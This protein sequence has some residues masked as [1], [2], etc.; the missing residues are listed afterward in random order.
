MHTLEDRMKAVG[1]YFKYGRK[2]ATARRELGYPSKGALR[3]WVKEYESTGTL[4]D[5]YRARA[6]KYSNQQEQAAVDYYL[7][8]GRSL[9]RSIQ[10]L[11]Y[12]NPETLRQWLDEAIPDRRGLR[13]GRSLRSKIEFTGEQKQAAVL[14]LC[15]R[16]GPAR[17]VAKKHG[18]TRGALYQWKHELLGKERSVT[19]PKRGKSRPNNDKDVLLARAESLKGQVE[20]LE[21]QVHRLQLERDVLEVT[22]EMLK[23]EQ[24]ADPKR[25]SNR[26]KVAAIGALR[27]RYSLNELL[28][29]LSI[30]KSSYF[31]QR[32]VLLASDKYSELRER[33]RST[34]A[35]SD[36]CY[37]YRRV[38]AILTRGGETVSEKV[39]RRL[40]RDQNLIVVGRKN[41]KYNSYKGEISPAVPNVIERDFHAEAPNT[42][43]VTDLTEFQIPA[44]K[45][46][47]S[48]MVDCFDGMAVSW[49]IGTSPDAGMVNSM[50]DNAISTLAENEHPLVH[51]DRGSHYRW[52][53][54]V[55]RMEAARLTRSMSKKGCSPDNAASEGFFGRI[56][57]ELFYGR[58]W[59]GVSIEEF[60]GKLHR[61]LH[62]YNERRIKISLG[63]KSPIEYRQSLGYAT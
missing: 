32:A 13:T 8:H 17:E 54:W 29:S 28:E 56:K 1:L 21:K 9:R 14:D 44:G 51:S 16:D 10:V 7:E 24:G 55:A 36:G 37:G 61:Y 53:G 34:F 59:A 12:P 11:G 23:K 27:D 19:K 22:A 49:S 42:K 45:V 40:M 20:E 25:L 50:L 6:P 30:P 35:E 62:W 26:E 15:S 39:V 2:S 46:Y 3:L 52:P 5:E 18:V 4:H 48:P 41:H 63:A 60:I 33:V 31:Y 38:H 58:S 43:W 47:L 57:N